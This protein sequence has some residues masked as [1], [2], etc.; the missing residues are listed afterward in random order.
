MSVSLSRR[1]WEAA[2][3]SKPISSRRCLPLCRSSADIRSQCVHDCVHWWLG[4][5]LFMK[6]I[7]SD[8]TVRRSPTPALH[9]A[10][11]QRPY[12]ELIMAGRDP[13]H[14]P[15]SRANAYL[16]SDR[17]SRCALRACQRAGNWNC[18]AWRQVTWQSHASGRPPCWYNV[19]SARQTMYC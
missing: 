12:H 3:K 10:A 1:R 2:V 19:N 16:L 18:T 7:P 11:T 14:T 13:G 17:A 6:V 9:A 4:S 8:F 5:A 15:L